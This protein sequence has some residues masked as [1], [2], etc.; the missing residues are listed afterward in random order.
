MSPKSL[1][2]VLEVIGQDYC[3][4]LVLQRDRISSYL[5]GASQSTGKE[6]ERPTSFNLILDNL[7]SKITVSDMTSDNQNR[8][9]HWCNH[10]AVMDRVN[11]VE[12]LD[13]KPIANILDIQNADVLPNAKDQEELMKNYVIIVARVFVE[14]FHC[15]EVFKDIVPCHIQHK[16]SKEMS[17]K[18]TKV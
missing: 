9:N 6:A 4:S 13:D 10:N 3:L 15:F 17:K 12:Y 14:H 1:N 7:D 2:K 5:K 8:D 11:P 16:H 18:S